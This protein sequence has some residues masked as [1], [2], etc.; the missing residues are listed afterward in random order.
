MQMESL[1][2]L[3]FQTYS[4]VPIRSVKTVGNLDFVQTSALAEGMSSQ[5]VRTVYDDN[6][7][8]KLATLSGSQLMEEYYRRNET[9]KYSYGTPMVQFGDRES[10]SFVT[11]EMV[12]KVPQK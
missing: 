2:H 6:F 5:S 7:F 9:T 10:S 11:V 8:N 3:Q 12:V 4:S 1:A